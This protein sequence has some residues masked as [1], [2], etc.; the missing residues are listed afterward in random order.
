VGPTVVIPPLVGGNKHIWVET[1]AHAGEIEA[2]FDEKL[3]LHVAIDTSSSAT[4]GSTSENRTTTVRCIEHLAASRIVRPTTEQ[5]TAQR[6]PSA[7]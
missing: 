5:Q 3:P 2:G 4:K 1:S 7:I 6:P